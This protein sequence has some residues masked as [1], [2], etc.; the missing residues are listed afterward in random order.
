MPAAV[1]AHP[2]IGRAAKPTETPPSVH[3]ARVARPWRLS[4]TPEAAESSVRSASAMRPPCRIV[5][6]ARAPVPGETKRRLV[7]ALGAERAAALHRAMIRRAVASAIASGVGSVELWCAPSTDHEV[8]R[9]LR[10][11][12]QVAL[13]TQVGPDLGARMHAAI[14]A[15]PGVVAVIGTDCPSLEPDDIAR[16]VDG[17]RA[18]AADVVIVPAFDGGYVLIAVDRPKPALFSGVEWGT[19][20]VLAQTRERA[21]AAGLRLLELEARHDIDRPEDLDALAGVLRW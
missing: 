9:A 3:D 20:R 1:A 7:P 13:R 16:A 15:R 8:F 10:D 21:H 14:E 18:A 4:G 17:L 19:A 2:R 6:M 12:A 11:D 5:V